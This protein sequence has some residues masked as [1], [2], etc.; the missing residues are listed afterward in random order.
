M[1]YSKLGIVPINEQNKAGKDI[2]YDEDFEKIEFEISKLTSPS[3]SNEV[4]WALVV[5]LCEGILKD[6]SKNLL[7]SAYFSY[8][9]FKTRA[10]DGLADGIKVLAD[11]IESYWNDLYPPI[12]RIKGR[13]NAIEWII[14]KISKE[15]E[16][17]DNFEI[18]IVKKDDFI[19]DLKRVDDF[20]NENVENAPLFYNLIKL[21]DMKLVTKT[22]KPQEEMIEKVLEVEE[23]V[24]QTEQKNGDNEKDFDTLVS[25]LNMLTGKMIE[26]K[27]YRSELFIINR[28]F[29]WLDIDELPSS[30][31]N[32]TMLPPPDTQEVDILKKLYE[33]KSYESLLW[34]AE[35]RITTYLFWL[36]LHYYVFESLKNLGFAQAAQTVKEQTLYFI[37][38]LPKLQNLSFSNSMPFANKITKQWL[39]LKKKSKDIK[40]MAESSDIQDIECNLK[41]IDKLCELISKSSCVEDEVLYNIKICRCLATGSNTTLIVVYVKKLLDK[42]KEYKIQEWSPKIALDSYLASVE[43][44][45]KIGEDELLEQLYNKIALLKPSLIDEIKG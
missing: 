33:E 29:S 4:D 37:N 31:K 6:K 34:A 1:D 26:S 41:G 3:A 12:R 10:I 43:C 11:M 42:I 36:D 5:K 14:D 20:L 40:E 9:L 16:N 2:K 22:L 7:V 28:A 27:D 17:I 32:V 39:S 45:E 23:K 44:L 15:L 24:E 30:D 35:S 38:K 13:I 18:D 21:V 8:A 19:N 25:S